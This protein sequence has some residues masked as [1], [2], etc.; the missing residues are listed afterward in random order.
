MYASVPL[1]TL[2]YPYKFDG[3]YRSFG[4]NIPQRNDTRIKPERHYIEVCDYLETKNRSSEDD[5]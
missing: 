3:E 5:I 1:H 4:E 2:E